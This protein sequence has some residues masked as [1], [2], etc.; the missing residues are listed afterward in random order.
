MPR[1]KIQN[2][3]NLTRNPVTIL[4]PQELYW[5]ISSMIRLTRW[6]RT[7]NSW[8]FHGFVGSVGLCI[9]NGS[10]CLDTVQAFSWTD[11]AERASALQPGGSLGWWSPEPALSECFRNSLPRQMALKHSPLCLF[12]E[13]LSILYRILRVKRFP[14]D[15]SQKTW[16]RRPNELWTQ[17]VLPGSFSSLWYF[18]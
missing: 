17:L 8:S 10:L 12:D 5:Q 7:T 4:T 18:I 3:H 15:W 9:R 6:V 1:V 11:P 16:S 14:E 2:A 13:L